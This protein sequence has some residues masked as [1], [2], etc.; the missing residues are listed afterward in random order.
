MANKY[1]DEK[2]NGSLDE[3][4]NYF[5]EATGRD[6][7]TQELSWL[8]AGRGDVGKVSHLDAARSYVSGLNTFSQRILSDAQN[9]YGIENFSLED[10]NKL[11]DKLY[12]AGD[13]QAYDTF[14]DR[15]GAALQNIKTDRIVNPQIPA[16]KAGQYAETVR[17]LFQENLGRDPKGYELEHFSKALAGGDDPFLL[18][19]TLQQSP[20]YSEIKTNKENERVKTESAAALNA[21]N[22]KLQA[23]DETVFNRA[24][25]T[26]MSSYQKA[27]RI[28]SSG[29]ANAL[30]RERARIAQERQSYVAGLDYDN[31]IRT[32]GYGREDFVNRGAQAFSQY[33][34]QSEPRYQGNAFA[35]QQ[36]YQNPFQL[37]QGILA[38]QRELADY[39]RQMSDYDRYA[40]QARRQQGRASLYGLA[41][42]IIGAGI[43]GYAMRR[44]YGS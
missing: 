19:M 8:S 17:S 38:R 1:T 21:L 20:E 26:I 28:G 37:S 29:V 27:G 30:T 10:A 25:P 16:D 24:L 2:V 12:I 43:Q 42:N 14:W 23:D 4:K 36:Q 11:R 32:Q 9:V 34:R 35:V 3:A 7:N 39:D 6:L 40:D 13:K 15:A 44:A 22:Q 33:L 41:G 31:A 18:A 5:K